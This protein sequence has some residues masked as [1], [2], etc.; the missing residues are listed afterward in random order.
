MSP[1]SLEDAFMDENNNS[2]TKDADNDKTGEGSHFE[3][4]W[5]KIPPP[6]SI[7]G[8]VTALAVEKTNSDFHVELQGSRDSAVQN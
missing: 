8:I 1:Y 7:N 4:Q 3:G 6:S 2:K 5:N